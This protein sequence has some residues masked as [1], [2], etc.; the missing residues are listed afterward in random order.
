MNFVLAQKNIKLVSDFFL[1]DHTHEA[2]NTRVLKFYE[3]FAIQQPTSLVRC[4][5]SSEKQPLYPAHVSLHGFTR[6][7]YLM[8]AG[9]KLFESLSL[10]PLY[11]IN[12]C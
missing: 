1:A 2:C 5:A 12:R 3:V 7:L 4:T 8:V 10:C 6:R 11:I 9:L